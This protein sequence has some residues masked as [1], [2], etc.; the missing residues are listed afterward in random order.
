MTVCDHPEAAVN[1]N[2][3]SEDIPEDE[4]MSENEVEIKDDAAGLDNYLS[5]VTQLLNLSGKYD[6]IDAF[7]EDFTYQTIEFLEKLIGVQ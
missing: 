4:D 3:A 6:I 1:A 5:A 7:G 2:G